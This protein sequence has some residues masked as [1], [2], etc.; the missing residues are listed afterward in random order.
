MMVRVTSTKPSSIQPNTGSD[1]FSGEA[2]GGRQILSTC[3]FYRGPMLEPMPLAVT[4]LMRDVKELLHDFCRFVQH[5]D[6]MAV[7]IAKD[8]KLK[9]DALVRAAAHPEALEG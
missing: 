3:V 1:L 7:E 2:S 4:R 6:P 5:G 9:I 8:I